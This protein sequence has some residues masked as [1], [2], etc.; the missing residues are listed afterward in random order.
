MIFRRKMMMRK[1]ALIIPALTMIAALSAQEVLKSAEEEYY[2]YLSLTGVTERPALGYRTLSDSTWRFGDVTSFEENDDGTF[3][4]TSVPGAESARHIWSGNNL[5]SR[6]V[7]WESGSPSENWFVR[8]LNQNITLRIYGPDWFNSINTAAPYGQNDGALWQGKGYNT[9]LSAGA[10]LEAY[11]FELTLRPQL[12]F[13]QNLAFEHLPGVYGNEYSYFTSSGGYIDLVQRYGDSAF[14]NFDWGDTEARWTWRNI[15]VG[16]G[17]QNPWLGPAYLNPMLGSNN[18][19]GYPKLDFGLRKTR[20]IIP[21]LGW[22][23][24]TIEGRVWVGKLSQSDYFSSTYPYDTMINALSASYAPSFIPGLTIGLNRIFLN[25]WDMK[26]LS[27]FWRLFTASNDNDTDGDGEDQKVSFFADWVFPKIGFK[28]YFEYGFDDFSS[29]MFSNPFH[30]GIY[31][32]GAAQIIPLKSDKLGSELSFE[33]NFFEMSQD[34]QLQW[35]YGGYYTHGKIRTGYTN[36][37]QVV[38]AGSG[39]FGNS[40][41]VQYRL[42]YPKGETSIFFHRYCPNINYVHNKAVNADASKPSEIWENYY[43]SYETYI[44]LGIKTEYFV[45][46]SLLL[47][48]GG[49]L[50]FQVNRMYQKKD[51]HVMFSFMFNVKY[52]F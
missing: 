28:V 12:S 16:F 48:G 4:R 13:S 44:T 6:Y 30:T 52:N 24:G 32:A 26:N 49:D 34:F 39:E 36:R 45:T 3:T 19:P 42:Y 27:Y 2:D 21:G 17:T 35:Q 9:S 47:S 51:N 14:W 5:G 29:N 37:G 1:S 33:L 15:T 8:G 50:I 25:R 7:L 23:L 41:F 20:I 43:A 11:G 40:Q 38:G 31:T 46:D 18:A 10:R 22:N